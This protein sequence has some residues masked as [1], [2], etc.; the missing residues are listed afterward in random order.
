MTLFYP[1]RRPYGVVA[2]I[3]G[4]NFPLLLAAGKIGPAFA[5][6]HSTAVQLFI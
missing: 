4:W 3:V 5:A 1:L 2:G 6:G